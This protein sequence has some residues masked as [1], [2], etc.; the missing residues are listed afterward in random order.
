MATKVM[1][2]V[3]HFG[4]EL[5]LFFMN[6]VTKNYLLNEVAL[7]FLHISSTNDDLEMERIASISVAS[8]RGCPTD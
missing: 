7:L 6:T 5:A 3:G 2:A 1:E 8:M 4:N